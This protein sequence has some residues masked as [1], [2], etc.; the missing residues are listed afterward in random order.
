MCS[1][2]TVFQGWLYSQLRKGNAMQFKVVFS[3]SDR[4]RAQVTDEERRASFEKELNTLGAE[5][6][7]VAKVEFPNGPNSNSYHALMQKS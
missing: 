7:V 3:A 6:W 4:G 2:P 5:G 1:L